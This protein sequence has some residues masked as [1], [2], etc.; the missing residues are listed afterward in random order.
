[1]TQLTF[2]HGSLRDFLA[3]LAAAEAPQPRWRTWLGLLA[4][5]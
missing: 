3:S 1:M 4:G 2:S 5:T